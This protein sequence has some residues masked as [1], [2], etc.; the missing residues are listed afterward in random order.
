MGSRLHLEK[1]PEKLA[2]IVEA[3]EGWVGEDR[4]I[5]LEEAMSGAYTHPRDN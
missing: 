1:G 4:R 3:T 5:R 2:I